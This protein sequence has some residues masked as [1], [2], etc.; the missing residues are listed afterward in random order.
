MFNNDMNNNQNFNNGNA[1][2]SNV[3]NN[4][5]L[6]SAQSQEPP[7]FNNGQNNGFIQPWQMQ[8]NNGQQPV[9][10]NN[11]F[12]T[13][14]YPG[15]NNYMTQSVDVPPDLGEIKNLSDATVASAPTMDVLG[16]MNIMPETLPPKNDPLD[17][18]ENGTLNMN[19]NSFIQPE[20]DFNVSNQPP[21]YQPTSPVDPMMQNVVTNQNVGINSFNNNQSFNTQVNNP[22]V[23]NTGFNVNNN[24]DFPNNSN[25][26]YQQPEVPVQENFNNGYQPNTPV[27]DNFNPGYEIPSTTPSYPNDVVSNG[28]SMVNENTVAGASSAT[29]LDNQPSVL[30]GVSS[31]EEKENVDIPETQELSDINTDKIQAIQKDELEEQPLNDDTSKEET[32]LSD[33]GLDE[34]Y[35]EPDMLEIMDL[36]NDTE[37]TTEESGD[38]LKAPKGLVADNVEKIKSLIENLKANG[39]DI[40]V[41]EFDFETMYQLIVKLNK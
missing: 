33:L 41:E 32:K 39:A 12:D 4:N 7:M 34:S 35:T 26:G 38:N 2:F 3:P 23:P 21:S 14:N 30:D 9:F 15:E 25:I 28:V 27:T 6:N 5:S 24:V 31:E 17:A 11:A 18:Y 36:D 37:S 1:M 10:G 29:P 16:P 19:A 13:N 8:N 40:E 22:N 20:Q